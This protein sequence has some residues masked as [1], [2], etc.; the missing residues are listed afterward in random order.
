MKK[1]TSFILKN[2]NKR[3]SLSNLN[4]VTWKVT[5]PFLTDCHTSFSCGFPASH[6]S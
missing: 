6:N 3:L 4:A 1:I 5:L 2:E